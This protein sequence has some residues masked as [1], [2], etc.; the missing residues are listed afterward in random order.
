[1]IIWRTCR[2]N[3][4]RP[5]PF[6]MTRRRGQV[7][8]LVD[9]MARVIVTRV[10]VILTMREEIRKETADAKPVGRGG[11]ALRRDRDDE[12]LIRTDCATLL[13]A[14]KHVAHFLGINRFPRR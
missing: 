6:I 4:M 14:L 2:I 9:L 8:I 12:R 1:R 7:P 13:D 3:P 11:I 10:P 5:Q